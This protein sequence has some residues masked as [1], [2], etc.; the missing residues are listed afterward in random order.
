MLLYNNGE[1]V[2]DTETDDDRDGKIGRPF[3]RFE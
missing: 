3:W 2:N 1:E